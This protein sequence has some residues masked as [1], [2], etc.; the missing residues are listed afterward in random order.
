V[1]L[2]APIEISKSIPVQTDGR[3]KY[4]RENTEL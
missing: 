1:S 4:S 2:K 3:N